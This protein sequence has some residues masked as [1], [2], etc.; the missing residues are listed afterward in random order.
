[1]VGV[2][3][4]GPIPGHPGEPPG[5]TPPFGMEIV[6]REELR[7]LLGMAPA[8]G[9]DRITDLG[10]KTLTCPIGQSVVGDVA[11]QGV[12]EVDPSGVVD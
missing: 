1:M 10:M 5:A 12:L 2:D 7:E 6:Q 9:E 4:L 8:S 11:D 3:L